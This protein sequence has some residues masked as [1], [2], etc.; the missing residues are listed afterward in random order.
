MDPT[1]QGE[2]NGQQSQTQGEGN[3]N[4]IN[5]RIGELTAKMREYERVAQAKDA[6]LQ[7]ALMMLARQQQTQQEA[8]QPQLPEGMD[9]SMAT[10]FQQM[11]QQQLAPFQQQFAGLQQQLMLTK[12][13]QVA[14]PTDPPEVRSR[15]EQLIGYWQQK[16]IRQF[17]V[18]DA[19]MFARGEHFSKAPPQSQTQANPMNQFAQ[20]TMTGQMP[21]PSVNVQ[22]GPPPLPANFDS[23]PEEQQLQLLEQRLAGKT[24]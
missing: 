12:V 6:Q 16:G 18:E 20:Q 4:G 3:Q 13:Q 11:L 21:P 15:A 22:Q 10:A 1:A 19:L 17:N 14:L 5:A 2:N 9:P 7:E 24:F 23:M 8:S